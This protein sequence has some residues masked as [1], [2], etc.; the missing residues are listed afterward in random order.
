MPLPSS[1]TFN[2]SPLPPGS[3]SSSTAQHSQR[4]Q[5]ALAPVPLDPSALLLHMN[6]LHLPNCTYT[7]FPN[8]PHPPPP[9]QTFLPLPLC[10][11]AAHSP[12]WLSTAPIP[13]PNTGYNSSKKTC[14]TRSCP[15]R[16]LLPVRSA[17]SVSVLLPYL[18]LNTL[19]TFL[20]TLPSPLF[21][22]YWSP[23]CPHHLAPRT[24][25]AVL[26]L[27]LLPN[28]SIFP[29]KLPSL[30]G[31]SQVVPLTAFPGVHRKV[32]ADAISGDHPHCS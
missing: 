32:K 8:P 12:L 1:Q 10:A 13:R 16:W 27:I 20:I 26:S 4:Y 21:S 14:L 22:R 7:L 5:L 11:Q 29:T 30:R 31:Q 28:S 6:F 24:C 9:P 17:P 18:F 15:G 2:G 23:L 19:L 3:S 25:Y